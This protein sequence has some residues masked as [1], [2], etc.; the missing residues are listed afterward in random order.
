MIVQIT[1]VYLLVF[2][3]ISNAKITQSAQCEICK[4]GIGWIQEIVEKYG[5]E[6][7][8]FIKPI[9]NIIGPFLNDLIG[10]SECNPEIPQ[11]CIDLC[12]GMISSWGP[13][14]ADVFS[15][16]DLDP[17]TDCGRVG[18]CPPPNHT[19]PI[20]PKPKLVPSGKMENATVGTIFHLSDIHYDRNY[21][22]GTRTDCGLPVCCH[23][24]YGPGNPGAGIYGDYNCDVPE[25]LVKGVL[26]EIQVR[27][28]T[29]VFYTGDTPA[30]D[31]W[32]QTHELNVGA[33]TNVTQWTLANLPSTT[34]YF[35]VIGNH[36]GAPV[37]EFGGP[38]KDFWLYGPVGDLWSK[39]LP[40]DS[41]V[42]FKWGGYYTAVMEPG[43]RVIGLQTNYYDDMNQWLDKD[44]PDIAGQLAWLEDVLSQIANLGEKAIIIGHEK[45][46]SFTSGPWQGLFMTIIS[47]YKDVITST[48]WGHNHCDYFQV[49]HDPTDGVTPIGTIFMPS[50]VTPISNTTNPSYRVFKYDQTT[51]L[52]LDYAQYRLDLPAANK[53]GYLTWEVAYTA[54]SGFNIPDMSPSSWQSVG[55]KI[56]TDVDMWNFFKS[57]YHGG[58]V[59][60]QP[61]G[62][63]KNQTEAKCIVL[64]DT[65]KTYEM[66]MKG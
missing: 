1:F 2:A 3:R 36:A 13:L 38:A 66:C 44:N 16:I 64:G 8:Q 4:E 6:V 62:L 19:K 63:D 37:D 17:E 18:L 28:P 39:F 32:L 23:S 55:E 51:K 52:L 29:Y 11:T 46:L 24:T 15:S 12:E 59:Y 25:V 9:C 7:I 34:K 42:S 57:V 10:S 31:L 22:P 14:I 5:N 65:D 30:H 43:L 41:I 49:M 20:Y 47:K 50:S 26:H 56:G 53:N 40:K 48:L 60:Y 21:V 27:N 54:L 58:V 45:P 35:P 33:I 61:E